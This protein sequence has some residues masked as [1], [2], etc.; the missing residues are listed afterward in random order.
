MKYLTNYTWAHILLREMSNKSREIIP[1][2]LM[3]MFGKEEKDR[4]LK[5]LAYVS[6]KKLDDDVLEEFIPKLEE[7]AREMGIPVEEIKQKEEDDSKW[8]EEVIR[9]LERRMKP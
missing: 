3:K 1:E 4:L 2:M 8:A 9:W 5:T 6:A 7:K